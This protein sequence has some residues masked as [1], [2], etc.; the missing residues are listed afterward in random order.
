[1]SGGSQS[2]VWRDR[3]TVLWGE[4]AKIAEGMI[5]KGETNPL[6]IIHYIEFMD[7]HY[8]LMA[9]DVEAEWAKN[10][11]DPRIRLPS[12]MPAFRVAAFNGQQVQ[13][14]SY[15]YANLPLF[16][17]DFVLE[18]G[19]FD[20]VI[21]LGCGYG[22]NLFKLHN[23]F[24]PRE[25]RYFG[26]ELSD[27]GVA[28]AQRL[29]ALD[30]GIDATFFKF[31]HLA[32]DLSPIGAVTHPLVFTCHSLEQIASVPQSFFETIASL[33]PRVTC[34]HLEPFGFQ[35]RPSGGLARQ[36]RQLFEQQGWNL[37]L[38]A[39]A[40]AAEKAG[41][42]K[43]TANIPDIFM[44]TDVLNMTSLMVWTNQTGKQPA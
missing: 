34:I 42:I 4:R 35:S 24:L 17:A 9:S 36:H 40:E 16:I 23:T 25:T 12:G 20:S 39:A 15:T 13:V 6:R 7:R 1:M 30:P 22:Q 11:F 28:L 32:A 19:P 3:Y 21:E 8:T 31:D 43:R 41:V 33:A 29:A 5:A 37:N 14:S 2:Q 18:H 27:A 26:G 10:Q 38:H 44:S